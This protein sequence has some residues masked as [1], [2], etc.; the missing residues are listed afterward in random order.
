MKAKVYC[1]PYT[2]SLVFEDIKLCS[3]NKKFVTGKFIPSKEYVNVKKVISNAVKDYIGFFRYDTCKNIRMEIRTSKDIDAP[4]KPI[5]DALQEL[6]GDDSNVIELSLI[7]IP[8]KRTLPEGLI[9]TIRQIDCQEC[10]IVGC[11]KKEQKLKADNKKA[12]KK[13]KT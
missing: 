13:H 10:G 12:T 2:M 3:I 6:I 9:I 8:D 4:V 5:L 7:K 11:Y 1:T